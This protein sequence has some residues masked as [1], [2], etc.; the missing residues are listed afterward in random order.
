MVLQ[1]APSV[2]RLSRGGNLSVLLEEGGRCDGGPLMLGRGCL[3]GLN[4]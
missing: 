1:I 4:L 3:F 2:S